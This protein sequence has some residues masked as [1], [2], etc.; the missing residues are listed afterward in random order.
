MSNLSP[1]LAQLSKEPFDKEGWL[2]E[3][4]WDGY[5]SLGL[6]KKEVKLISRNQKLFNARFPTIAKELK[7]IPGTFLVDGEIVIL[8]KKGRSNFQLMQNY[9]RKKEGTPLYYLFDILSYNGKDLTKLPLIERKEILKSLLKRAKVPHIK[10][11]EH[12]EKKGKAFFRKAVKLGLEGIMAKKADSTYQFRR[13]PDWQKIKTHLRQEVVIGGFTEPKGSRKNFGA[14]LVG[15]YEKNKLIY[16]GHVG[17]GFD[18]NLLTDI[19]AKLKKLITSKC[20]FANEP[21]PNSPAIWVKPKLV[22]EVSFAEWTNDGIMRQP[23]FKG[24]RIDKSAKEV[25]RERPK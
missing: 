16:V 11:S 10:F 5:R 17:T 25:V 3:I 19:Y 18:Q 15:V 2:F 4:K 7:K 14:L 24:L 12:I 1:M 8:D 13:S 6:K 20:P 9:Q 22:A 21:D 23:V